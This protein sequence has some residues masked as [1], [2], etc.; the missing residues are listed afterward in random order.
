MTDIG[1][2]SSTSTRIRPTSVLYGGITPRS[3]II[4]AAAALSSVFQPTAALAQRAIDLQIGSWEVSGPNSTLYSAGFGRRFLGPLSYNLRGL[5]LI[6]GDSLGDRSLYGLAPELSL[7]RGTRSLFPY[8]TAGVGL[9]LQSTTSPELVALWYAGVGVEMNPLPWFGLALEATYLAEDGGFRGFRNLTEEDRRGWVGSV[10]FSFRWGGGSLGTGTTAS[11]GSV[12]PE[13][14]ARQ[15]VELSSEVANTLAGQVVQTALGAMG[16]PYRWGGTSS[17]E[18]FDCSGLIWYSYTTHGISVPRVS[19]DQAHA[20]R[21]VGRDV[22]KLEPGDI[23]LFD[24][25]GNGVSHV[26]LYI[27]NAQFIHSTT[28]GGVRVG[29]LDASGD[30]ND[31]WW[32]DRWVGARRVLG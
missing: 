17:D 16:E 15:P 12:S 8:L 18:G 27:G 9:A 6:D 4:L 22:S 21:S 11:P 10:R 26:G 30:E 29:A 1:L 7:L 3:F 28:S 5:A 19:R 24:A 14:S 31:R 13:T 23:L 32:R 25:R 2:T 20:G